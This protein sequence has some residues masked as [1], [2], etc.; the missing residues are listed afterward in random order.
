M[1]ESIGEK[2]STL[3]SMLD[4]DERIIALNKLDKE[5]SNNEEVMKLSYALDV[6]S[7]KYSDMLSIYRE[8][9]KEVKEARLALV[10]AKENLY[11]HPLVKQYLEVYSRVRDLYMEVD[12]ILFADYKRG[13]C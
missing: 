12:N 6:A 2:V 13:G 7:S 5:M 1:N 9:S 10:A 8:D 11:S 4:S 3:K